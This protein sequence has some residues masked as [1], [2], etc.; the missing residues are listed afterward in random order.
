M[1]PV[2]TRRHFIENTARTLAAV[3]LAP[4]VRAAAPEPGGAWTIGCLNRPWTKWS[5][6]EMLDSVKAAGFR[7]IG[8]QTP[9][10]A[11]PFVGA[12]A[13]R[14]Y[15]AALK[16]KIAARGLEAF[17][18]RVQTRDNATEAD[19][20]AA[21]RTQIDRAKFLGLR[22]LINTGTAKPEAYAAW[23]RKMALAAAYGADHGVQIV[24]KPHGGVTAAAPELL[25]CLEKV[26]HPNFR[27]W[28][29]AGNLI[30]YTGKD[31]IA[32]LEPLLPHVTAFTAK[33]CAAKGAEVMT[34]FGTGKV[35]FVAIF[36]RL[37]RAGF[38]GPIVVESCAVGA[39]AAETTAN[40]R[41]NRLFLEKALAGI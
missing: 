24:V 37:K 38:A 14:D 20:A 2:T 27:L 35:D 30:Y 40:A 23:Y 1:K 11:D 33:D 15:L 26:N 10:P 25:T 7:V 8:L 21:I 31:P 9:T 6:D 4:A 13:K 19:E 28:Y 32:D 16:D 34:Q 22:V 29:D 12:A 5:A 36:R 39:T 18:G 41:A 17:Q 3:V